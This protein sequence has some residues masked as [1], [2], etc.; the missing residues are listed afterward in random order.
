MTLFAC[1]QGAEDLVLQHA[2]LARFDAVLVEMDLH[3]VAKN[4][5]VAERL[6]AAGFLLFDQLRSANWLIGGFSDV[7]VRRAAL[8]RL[9]RPRSAYGVDRV[10]QWGNAALRAKH[11][12]VS[13]EIDRELSTSR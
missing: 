5:R 6:R 7:Y 9:N 12:N 4:A 1:R 2:Q 13:Q 3:N 11:A 10:R 8:A